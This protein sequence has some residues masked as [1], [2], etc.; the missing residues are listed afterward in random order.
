MERKELLDALSGLRSRGAIKRLGARADREP[1]LRQAL[2][3]LARERGLSLP[4]DLPGKKLIRSVLDRAGDA[5]VRQ[6][7]IHRDESFTC[8]WCGAAVSPGGARVRDHCPHCLRSLHVDNVPGDRANPCHGVLHPRRFEL[9]E[10]VFHIHYVC[11]RCGAPHRVRAH[12][13]D[14]LPPSLN[15]SDLPGRAPAPSSRARTMP[16]R[17]LGFIRQHGLW[18][19]GERVVVAVSG[20]VDS[21]ALLEILARTAGAHGGRL[22]VVSLDHGLRAASVGEVAQVRAQAARLKLPFWTTRLSLELG[23]N[24]YARAREARREAL[25]SRHADRIATAHHETDQAETVLYHLLRGSGAR[26]LR[27]ML[28]LSTPWCRPLLG[29]PRDLIVEWARQEELPW[30]DDPSNETSQ[31]GELRRLMPQLNQIHGGAAGALARTG[32]L[33]AREDA[34]L[35]DLA[36]A[37]WQRCRCGAALRVGAL[38][39]EHPAVQLRLLQRLVADCP[40]P[41]RADQLEAFFSWQP[42]GGARLPLPSGWALLYRDGMLSVQQPPAASSD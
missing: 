12:P 1:T 38:R 13:D 20:G 17:V 11:G 29:E 10:G 25:L 5:Q 24:L 42:Q 33:L 4:D 18:E 27:G 23:P 36:D 40:R 30:S 19:P 16:Q 37:A 34:L 41:V 3:A 35:C 32:R 9:S 31:R 28:P 6:N 14:Q 2:L 15:P 26:G 22:E 8:A 7:P 39:E 21:T